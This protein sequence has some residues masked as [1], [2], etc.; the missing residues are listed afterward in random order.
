[1][2]TVGR[3]LARSPGGLYLIA[4]TISSSSQPP[5]AAAVQR[6]IDRP[7]LC[8]ILIDQLLTG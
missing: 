7:P 2:Q 6:L 3:L 8:I 1:M 4:M 5:A